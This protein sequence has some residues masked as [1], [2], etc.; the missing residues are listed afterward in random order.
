[1][2][3]GLHTAAVEVHVDSVIQGLHS[4]WE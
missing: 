4:I 1:M 2:N 3:A